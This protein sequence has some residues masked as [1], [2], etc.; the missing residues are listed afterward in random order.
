MYEIVKGKN[1]ETRERNHRRTGSGL[2]KLE[3]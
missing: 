3:K 2:E 1:G